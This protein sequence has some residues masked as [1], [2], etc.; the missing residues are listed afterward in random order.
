MKCIF[1]SALIAAAA[2]AQQ[3]VDQS[4][5]QVGVASTLQFDLV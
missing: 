3:V 5:L 2:S 4:F 1:A